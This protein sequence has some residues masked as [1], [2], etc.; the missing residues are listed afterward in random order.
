MNG[1]AEFVRF[2]LSSHPVLHWYGSRNRLDE[3]KF[4]DHFLTLPPVASTLPNLQIKKPLAADTHLQWGSSFTLDGE[5]AETL[6][7]GGAYERFKGT[8]RE[9]KTIAEQKF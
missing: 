9:A 5:L 4:F 6:V 1:G 3:I 2:Q 8:A 7:R